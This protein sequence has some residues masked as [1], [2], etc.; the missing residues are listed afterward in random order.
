MNT[1]NSIKVRLKLAEDPLQDLVCDDFQ[2]HKG[3]IETLQ[4]ASSADNIATFNSIKVRLK[5]PGWEAWSASVLLS[6]P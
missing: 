2:F 4:S 3:A 1:F 6:I 5:P